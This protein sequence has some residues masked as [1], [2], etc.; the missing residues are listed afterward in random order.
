MVKRFGS[1]G[2]GVAWAGLGLAAAMAAPSVP[3]LARPYSLPIASSP[4]ALPAPD[5]AAVAAQ[6]E[7]AQVGA[8]AFTAPG[9]RP[10]LVRHVV[11]FRFLRGVTPFQKAEI[12]RRFLELAVDSRRPDGRSVVRSI[13]TGLQ[14]GGEG[15]DDGYEMGF[16]VTFGSEGDRNYYVGRPVVARPGFFDPAH[17]AFKTFLAPYLA[18]VLSF[19]YRVAAESQPP[20]ASPPKSVKHHARRRK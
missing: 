18:G 14:N 19:D 13:E 9:F 11:L 5:A 16:L 8:A 17:D 15:Q 4:P 6:Q 2:S 10:G 12:A 3:A 7:L 1:V 20:S